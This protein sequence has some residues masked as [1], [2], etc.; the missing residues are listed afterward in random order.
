MLKIK[1]D[2]EQMD[3]SMNAI[4]K[5]IENIQKK[6]DNETMQILEIEQREAPKHKLMKQRNEKMNDLDKI[7]N[8]LSLNVEQRTKE[9]EKKMNEI[10]K[11]EKELGA[12]KMENI[13]QK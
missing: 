7:C 4:K 8:S 13:E 11:M 12:L 6:I 1:S 5:D 2:F 3:V 10:A 9:N